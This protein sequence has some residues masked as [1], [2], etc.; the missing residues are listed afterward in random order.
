MVSSLGTFI[1]SEAN[2]LATSSR[3]RRRY[4]WFRITSVKFSCER[5]DSFHEH[6]TTFRTPSSRDRGSELQ[7]IVKKLYRDLLHYK[8]DIMVYLN[9]SGLIRLKLEYGEPSIKSD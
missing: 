4:S 6:N 7:N 8:P 9:E 5:M 1:S 3:G 2:N